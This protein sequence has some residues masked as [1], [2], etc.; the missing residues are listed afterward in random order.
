MTARHR[1][2]SGS[3]L[4]L[5]AAL[6]ALVAGSFAVYASVTGSGSSQSGQAA[7]PEATQPPSTPVT[8]RTPAPSRSPSPSPTRASRPSPK[9]PPNHT[10]SPSPSGV[11][12]KPRIVQKP[13]PFDAKRRAETVAYAKRHYGMATWQLRHPHVIVEHYTAGPSFASAYNTFAANSPDLGELPGTCAHFV[14]DTDGTIYQLVPL[15]T[16]CR[17]TVGLNW[18]AV[19]IEHVGTSDQQV[20]HDRAQL[21]ASL[22]LTLWLME[23]YGISLPN[24]IGHSESLSS[25]F[26]HENVPSWRCQTHADWTHADM[27]T[28]RGRLSSLAEREGV[29]IAT[30]PSPG[31]SD[32]TS[33]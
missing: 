25:P 7:G 23:R 30:K 13:I 21:E 3:F 29:R 19:G 9:P 11:V 24:V 6:L 33:C 32:A 31:S 8:T 26:H 4:A 14:I 20:L 18:T 2:R 27:N 22:Q 12:P 5:V 10:G 15:G 17:H 1:K 16:M 28:Y